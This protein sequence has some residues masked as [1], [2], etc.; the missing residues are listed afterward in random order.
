MQVRIVL[1]RVG[2]GVLG[3]EL[4][5]GLSAWKRTVRRPDWERLLARVSSGESDG[6]VVWHTDRLFG[7]PRYLETL[8]EWRRR[9]TRCSPRTARGTSPTPTTGSSC[10]KAILI[11]G[12]TDPASCR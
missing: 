8:I 11:T 10:G 7:H 2:G 3:L 1:V 6:C 12:S 4:E 9:A 5:D